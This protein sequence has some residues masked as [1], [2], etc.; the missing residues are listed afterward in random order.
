[1]KRSSYDERRDQKIA[2]E[3]TSSLLPC[4]SCGIQTER[5]TLTEY[6]ARCGACYTF[7][8]TDGRPLP[9]MPSLAQRKAAVERLRGLVGASGNPMGWV[10]KLKAR[11]AAGE[12][13]N[14]A[15][16]DALKRAQ[17]EAQEQA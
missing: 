4:K 6:G 13:L 16:R 14:M 12:R 7:Y 1:M 8:I 3:F 10:D 17:R 2:D 11:E 15:Q 9:A 5:D